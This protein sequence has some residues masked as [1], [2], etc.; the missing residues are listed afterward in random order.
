MIQ[1]VS[2]Y[3]AVLGAEIVGD[4]TL[5]TVGSLAA[6]RHAA[7]VI[8]GALAA[9]VVKMAAAVYLGELLARLPPGLLAI[10]GAVTFAGL[11]L[12]VWRKRTGPP[13]AESAVAISPWRGGLLAFAALMFTEWADPGQMA[14]ALMAARYQ[15]PIGVLVAAVLA[16]ATKILVAATLGASL[17]RRVSDRALRWFTTAVCAVMCVLAAFQIEL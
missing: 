1:L 3:V 15:A 8:A 13:P 9:A 17:R 5:Y 10:T 4:K 7:P 6:R 14:A 16:M 2:V 11:A 12:S